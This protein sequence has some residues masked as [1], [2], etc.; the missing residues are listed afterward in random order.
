MTDESIPG[1]TSTRALHIPALSLVLLVGP[2]GSGK[3]TF[4]KRHFA[5]T[6]VISS[7]ACRGWVSD[8][9]NSQSATN[10]AFELLHFMVAKRLERG[11][12]TVVDATNVQAEARRPLV[13]L[14]RRF[15]CLP[16]AIVFNLPETLCHERNAS[17]PDRC[18]GVHVVRQQAAQMRRSLRFLESEGFRHVHHLCSSDEING[19]RIER[20]P[21]WNDLRHER[22]P[23]DLIGD[24]H[25]C[26]DE[27]VALLVKLGHSVDWGEE[28]PRVR[29]APG[30]KLV[31]LGDL[32]DRGP[33]VSEVLEL[34]MSACTDGSAL[35]VP[36]NHDMKLMRAL[37]GKKVMVAHGLAESLEQ[38]ETRENRAPGWK[39]R[40][41]RFLDDL[42]SHYVLDGGKLVVAHA[43]MREDMQ[44][45]GSGAVR[46]FAL[47]GE[48][49]GETD[50]FG[51]PVR[52]PW[53][54][55][56]RG[57]AMVV[58]GHTPVPEP[59]WLNRTI[60]I[61]TGCVFGGRLTALRYPE[62]ELV[63]VP[64]LATYAQPARPLHL[65]A[66]APPAAQ[67]IE[68]DILDWTDVSGKRVVTTRLVPSITVR[69]EN[70][71]AATEVL[72]RFAVDPKWL[73]YL[74]PTMPPCDASSHPDYL[75]HPD[76]AFSYYRQQG[77]TSV[78]CEEKHMGSRA[79]VII[80]RSTEV[81][82]K[83]FGIFRSGADAAGVV[84]TRT[85]RRFFT[86]P[87]W[88]SA[89]LDRVRVAMDACGKWELWHTD[90]AI[91]DAELMP[92]SAKA[93][94]LIKRPYASTGA[95]AE[96]SLAAASKVLDPL[97]QVDAEHAQYADRCAQRAMEIASYRQAYRQHAAPVTQA[98]ELRLAPFHI[99]A[100][101][102]GV[103][104]TRPHR[105]HLDEL[106]QLVSAIEGMPALVPTPAVEV[107]VTDATSMEAAVTWWK[108]STDGGAEGIVIKPMD[109]VVR[110]SRGLAQPAVKCR[111]PAYLRIIY[112]PEYLLKE[113]LDRLRQRRLAGKRSLALREFALGIE[114][115]ERFVRREPLRR[116]HECVLGILA[117]ESQPIDPRL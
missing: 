7:D 5:A 88:E 86:S 96:A 111:G 50:E 43:G 113:N 29:A 39:E 62:L 72:S 15:H 45:R 70:A 53:A 66:S 108:Q 22:G 11:R 67:H 63:S 58:Y 16:V 64:A 83:R 89:V 84:Y 92:W 80:C 41:V 4:A 27:L 103:H 97:R 105:W 37:R 93:S 74:P 21:L 12:L 94:E 57:D 34:A 18:F 100:T 90:W 91:F 81:A 109:F 25:G 114:A 82:R 95:A 60:N 23:F 75:E 85:G 35:C 54:R 78:V 76:E 107:D 13:A 2:T 20:D 71:V 28:G 112:G 17:R 110:G 56:Y 46:E 69:A 38:I 9:E 10:D 26:Y 77:V 33:K 51:L 47:Y 19:V 116:I 14:A 3:S 32:V 117:L 49:T 48:T 65:L 101:E 87:D 44:G 106:G 115:L 6:E 79:I 55:D 59:E 68:D 24:V 73:V 99:L 36:G 8:D 98:T 52:Y 1:A 102:H 61:D 42:V 31:F 30:R 104:F 40:V